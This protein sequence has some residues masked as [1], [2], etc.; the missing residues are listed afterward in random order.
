MLWGKNIDLNQF[1]SDFMS[2][3]IEE[4][5]IEFEET[6]DGRGGWVIPKSFH[7]K[8]DSMGGQHL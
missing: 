2:V 3:A 8:M 1:K 6:I 7:I 5:Q 4:S